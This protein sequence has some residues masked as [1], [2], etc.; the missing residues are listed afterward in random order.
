MGTVATKALRLR[1]GEGSGAE[2]SVPGRWGKGKQG[3]QMDGETEAHSS[4]REGTWPRTHSTLGRW[5]HLFID[6]AQRKGFPS[7]ALPHAR[8]YP[9]PS[10][11]HSPSNS[12]A[13]FNT[14]FQAPPLVLPSV[15]DQTMLGAAGLSES[16]RPR[17][18]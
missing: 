7:L 6:G 9:R 17:V 5:E 2:V 8:H 15:L 10:L 11:P 13:S 16:T 1:P 18:S 3:Q 14:P 4:E 12:Y